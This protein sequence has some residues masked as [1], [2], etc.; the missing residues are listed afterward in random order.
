MTYKQRIRPK[1][2]WVRVR[3]VFFI[4]I[5]C[6]ALYTPFYGEYKEAKGREGIQ[7]DIIRAIHNQENRRI[8]RIVVTSRFGKGNDGGYLYAFNDWRVE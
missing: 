8:G 2:I 5:A 1:S 4:L 6:T 3:A 7:E